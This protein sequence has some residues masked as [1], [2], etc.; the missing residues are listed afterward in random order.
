MRAPDRVPTGYRTPGED[1]PS[2]RSNFLLLAM[3]K[4]RS[5]RDRFAEKWTEFSTEQG[6]R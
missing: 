2:P 1:S 5:F 6:A 3:A 4:R